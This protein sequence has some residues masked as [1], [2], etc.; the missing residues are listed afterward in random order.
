MV[1]DGGGAEFTGV[2]ALTAYPNNPK[3]LLYTVHERVI[4]IGTKS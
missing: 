3:F 2:H 1:G 4:R